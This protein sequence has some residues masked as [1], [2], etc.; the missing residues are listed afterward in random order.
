V[1]T[2]TVPVGGSPF[3]VAVDPGS[4]TVYVADIEHGAVSVIDGSTRVVT[5]TVPVGGSPFGVAVDPGSRTVYVANREH[6]T[7]ILIEPR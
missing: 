4:R 1:V 5:D 3:G 2:D 7:V 6:G